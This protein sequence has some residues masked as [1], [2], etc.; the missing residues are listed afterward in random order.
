MESRSKTGQVTLE[1]FILFAVVALVTVIGLT[2][3]HVDI[4]K[5][6]EGFFNAAANRMAK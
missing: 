2:A 3:F 6:L 5:V 4:R 1:F